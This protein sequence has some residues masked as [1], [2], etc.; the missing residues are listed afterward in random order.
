MLFLCVHIIQDMNVKQ[1]FP[2]I[3]TQI[4]GSIYA[5][6]NKS[7]ND[8]MYNSRSRHGLELI[9]DMMLLKKFIK[10]NLNQKHLTF[11]D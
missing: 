11:M 5:N 9:S 4:F 1:V 2:T 10:E 6:K 3:L 7:V 8:F